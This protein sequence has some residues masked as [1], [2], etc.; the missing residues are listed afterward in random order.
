MTTF[1]HEL[2]SWWT[3]AH[4]YI[5]NVHFRILVLINLVLGATTK[6]YSVKACLNGISIYYFMGNGFDSSA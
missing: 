6:A 3:R 1:K 4:D 5:R 2:A